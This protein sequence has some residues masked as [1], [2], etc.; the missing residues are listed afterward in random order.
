LVFVDDNP[1][2]IGEVTERLPDVSCVIVPEELAYLP[3]LLAETEFFD[4]AEVT[5][6]DRQRTEMM[7]RR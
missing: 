7:A 1:K 6:E 3:G 5:D 2:E 4:F